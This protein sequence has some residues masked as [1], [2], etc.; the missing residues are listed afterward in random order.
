MDENSFKEPNKVSESAKNS[1]LFNI[2]ES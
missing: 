2:E 1:L